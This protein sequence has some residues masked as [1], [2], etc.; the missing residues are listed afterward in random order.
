VQVLLCQT[1]SDYF[2]KT[3]AVVQVI[4]LALR[5][6]SLLCWM[7]ILQQMVCLTRESYSCRDSKRSY[8]SC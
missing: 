6:L 1:K 8:K 7:I 2:H 4:Y 5:V 3:T